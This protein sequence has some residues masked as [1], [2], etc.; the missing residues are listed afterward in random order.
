MLGNPT[1]DSR[2]MVDL[3]STCIGRTRYFLD[4]RQVWEGIERLAHTLPA[5]GHLGDVEC[6]GLIVEAV[7]PGGKWTVAEPWVRGIVPPRWAT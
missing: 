7:F 2:E 6:R 1:L 4:F 5:A 3:F